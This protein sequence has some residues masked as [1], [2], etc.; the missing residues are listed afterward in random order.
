MTESP[1]PLT[2]ASSASLDEYFSRR[3]PFDSETLAKI[4]SEFRRLR[5]RWQSFEQEGGPKPKSKRSSPTRA[6]STT[7]DIFSEDPNQAP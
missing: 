7:V 4:K 5:E 2:E 3:P 1:S 6:T